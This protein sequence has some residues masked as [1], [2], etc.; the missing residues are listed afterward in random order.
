MEL[1][2]LTEST[3]FPPRLL[4]STWCLRQSPSHADSCAISIIFSSIARSSSDPHPCSPGL[5]VGWSLLSQTQVYHGAS[6]VYFL[7]NQNFLFWH[8]NTSKSIPFLPFQYF[9][10]LL[11]AKMVYSRPLP[12]VFRSPGHCIFCSLHLERPSL[13]CLFQFSALA[14]PQDHMESFFIIIIIGINYVPSNSKLW[15]CDQ[16]ISNFKNLPTHSNV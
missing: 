5:L 13:P 7:K 15:G 6:V 14:A 4:N 1:T 10:P 3:G 12:H 2:V 8:I 11:S 16:G 9:L